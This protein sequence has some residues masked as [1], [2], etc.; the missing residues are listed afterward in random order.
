MLGNTKRDIP[1]STIKPRTKVKTRM[2]WRW[3]GQMKKEYLTGDH[4][5]TNV[6]EVDHRHVVAMI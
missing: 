5:I 6:I 3:A 2:K 1:N 4:A